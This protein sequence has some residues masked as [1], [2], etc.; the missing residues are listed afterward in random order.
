MYLGAGRDRC[1][2][3]TQAHGSRLRQPHLGFRMGPGWARQ[4]WDINPE[5]E[6]REAWGRL[7]TGSAAASVGQELVAL[8]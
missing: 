6:A 5:A 3:S 7:V 2:V 4:G 8:G 1:S